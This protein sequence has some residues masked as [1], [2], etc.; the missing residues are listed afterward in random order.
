MRE[1]AETLHTPVKGEYDVVVA[2]A[3]VAG[4]CAA[5]AAKR[6]GAKN[7]LLL[8]KAILFGGMATLG[9]VALYEP[10]CNGSGKKISYGMASELMQLCRRYGPDDLPQEWADDPDFV[11]GCNKKY[12]TFFSPSAFAFALDEFVR[13]AGVDILFDT[14]AVRPVMDGKR[15]T[16]VTVENV[17]GRGAY[18]LKS[19]VDATGD[20]EL[21]YKAGVPCL[22]G[23]NHMVYIAYRMDRESLKKAA[24]TGNMLHLRKWISLGSSPHENG[25]PKGTAISYGTTAEE[26]TQYV[27]QGRRMMLESIREEDRFQRDMSVL[28]AMPQ[29][30]EIRRIQGAYTLC[31]ADAKKEQA[32]SVGAV[33]DFWHT[34]DWYEIPYRAL[35]APAFPNVWTAGRSISAKDWAWS[36]VRVIPGCACSGQAAGTAA[37]ICAKEAM[38]AAEL[39]FGMLLAALERD[40]AKTHGGV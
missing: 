30:R 1:I 6:A 4:A 21:L 8:E 38:T 40:G 26:I 11:P 13:N 19:F 31:E 24:E 17:S 34:G 3:G 15:L 36:A 9:L 27:L 32:D 2:G 37:A 28:P 35:Y 5:V 29:L 23:K 25:R 39:P 22:E 10:L 14:R 20:A 7:V 18:L 33:A 12:R 16:A